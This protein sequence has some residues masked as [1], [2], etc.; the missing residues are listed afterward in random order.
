MGASADVIVVGAGSA[1]S[2]A[3][4]LLARAGLS[5]ALLDKEAFP[6]DKPCAGLLSPRGAEAVARVYGAGA[7]AEIS[8]QACT[9][10][11]M[12]RKDRLIGEIT[13][14]PAMHCLHRRQADAWFL[15][16]ASAAGARV[17]QSAEVREVDAAVGRVTLRS[18]ETLD[19][20][21]IIG[22]DGPNSVV[23]RCAWKTVRGRPKG[24]G[25]SLIAEAPYD[26]LKPGETREKCRLY[27]HVY[28]DLMPWGYGWVFPQGAAC[29][30]GIG[31]LVRRGS[32]FRAAMRR[33]V[34][35]T[36]V[37][38]TFERL[39]LRGHSL[40]FGNFSRTPAR[41]H[42]LLVGDAAGLAEPVT[43]EGIAF[44]IESA[45]L[46]AQAVTDAFADGEA[47]SA[48]RRYTTLYRRAIYPGFRQAR[49]ARLLLYPRLTLPLAMRALSRNEDRVRWFF[50]IAS[51]QISYAEYTRRMLRS[52][53]LRRGA[54]KP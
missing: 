21:I 41:G 29:T 26:A 40:P 3:A 16:R 6:R 7:L 52:I 5:V 36:C 9:G 50:E 10:A 37:E 22:A 33:L 45:E 43:G 30:I 39:E 18:G 24:L 46:A 32:G 35:M 2:A 12:F 1:G 14:A 23:R 27:P 13:G 38:G 48:S 28:F 17:M 47:R 8:L 15:A 31:G 51:G 49:W 19:A 25:F 11:R 4:A 54:R 53:F 42:V 34:D 44:A 20:K